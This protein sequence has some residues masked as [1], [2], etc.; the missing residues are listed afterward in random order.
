MNRHVMQGL[1]EPDSPPTGAG[2]QP[3]TLVLVGAG[4]A[5][6]HVL[7]TLAQHPIVGV[8][9]V[10]VAPHPRLVVSAMV[11]AWVAGLYQDNDCSIALEPLVQ[12]AGV[13]WLQC[14]VNS[15]DASNQLLGLDDGT[16]LSYAWLSIHTG[17]V[18]DRE[19]IEAATPGARANALFVH[20]TEGFLALWP[21]VQALGTER[22]LRIAVVGCTA[23]AVAWA[24]ALRHRLPNAA[25]TLICGP[26]GLAA[27]LGPA[28]QETLRASLRKRCI[29][30]LHD[31]AVG[32]DDDQVHLRQGGATLACDVP[33]LVNPQHGPP[34]LHTSGLALDAQGLIVTDNQLRSTSHTNVLACGSVRAQAAL[35]GTQAGNSDSSSGYAGPILA[36]NLAALAGQLPLKVLR[37]PSRLFTVLSLGDGRAIG[38]WGKLVVQG[39]WVW[40]LQRAVEM[41]RVAQYRSK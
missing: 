9:V 27:T 6:I 17:R 41:R 28:L 10:L 26:Q 37:A 18:C 1:T 39:R 30:V 12:R 36:H 35:T 16:S 13:R 8:Q 20:P 24:F 7:Q 40:W 11:P 34:W 5:H 4:Q 15:L 29:T 2:Y 38:R 23:D 22:A 19:Q 32:F 21:R 3:R 25:V 14:S 33:V 31:E